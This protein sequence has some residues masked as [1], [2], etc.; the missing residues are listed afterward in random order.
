MHETPR[1]GGCAAKVRGSTDPD[2]GFEG[3]RRKGLFPR[4]ASRQTIHIQDTLVC[5]CRLEI[6]NH[7]RKDSFIGAGQSER[8]QKIF[9]AWIDGHLRANGVRIV[10]IDRNLDH[11]TVRGDARNGDSPDGGRHVCKCPRLTIYRLPKFAFRL[12]LAKV[13][14]VGDQIVEGHAERSIG[15]EASNRWRRCGGCSRQAVL[16]GP[17][18]MKRWRS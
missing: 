14:C 17:C 16:K 2:D 8:S 15:R 3:Q 1:L 10:G 12:C 11:G 9:Y 7:P 18:Y 13:I 5:F 4:R 6:R